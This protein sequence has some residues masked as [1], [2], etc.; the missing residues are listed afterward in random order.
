MPIIKLCEYKGL[1][2]IVNT[3]NGTFISLRTSMKQV[4]VLLLTT[5]MACGLTL[6][7]V[8]VSV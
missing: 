7:W 3:S 8:F 1:V 2:Y 4:E 6:F 5:I